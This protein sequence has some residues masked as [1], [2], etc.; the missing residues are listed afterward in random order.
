M[1]AW[2]PGSYMIR[3]L[4]ANIVSVRAEADG[5]PL[6]LTKTDKSTWLAA[7][8][9]SQVTLV[10][11]IFAFDDSVRGAYL[12]TLRG[13]FDGACVFPAVVGQ[14][15]CECVVDIVAPAFATGSNWRV[16]TSMQA[17]QAETNAFGSYH[18]S[19]YA[20][21]IDHPVAMGDF[22]FGEFDVRGIPHRI[23]LPADDQVD[24]PRLCADLQAL[25]ACHVDFLRPPADLDRYLF[26]VNS[27]ESGYG[28]LEHR[29]S[30]SLMCSRSD[31]PKV[32]QSGVSE[33]YRKF[34]GLCS[35]EYFHL[36]N[37]KRIRPAA[38]ANGK[39][40]KENYTGLLWVF[41]GITS[42]YDDLL[43][44]RSGLIT[45][46]SYLE[47][48][49]RTITRVERTRGRFRQSVEESSFDAWTKFYKRTVNTNNAVVSYYAKGSLIALALDL[50]IR[51]QSAGEFSLDDVMHAA[52]REYGV[53]GKGM[54]EG[55]L[56]S[57]A[58]SVTG[59][60]LQDFFAQFV[61]GT[62]DLPLQ[63][64]LIDVGLQLHRRPQLGPADNGGKPAAAGD[65]QPT[66]WFGA[67][68]QNSGSSTRVMSVHSDS[69][70]EVSGVAPGDE[71]VALGGA[72]L[73]IANINNRLQSFEP[74]DTA[75]LT[76]FRDHRLLN[77]TLAF[78]T[79][80]PDD[81]AYFTVSDTA[82]DD[83][84]KRRARWLTAT[85]G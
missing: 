8:A 66:V 34:L 3:D 71:L 77:L 67:V 74:G 52:W 70:A 26:I 80:A 61:R 54:P 65:V 4:A 21:L 78:A 14:E 31:L 30:T 5:E 16:A 7:P 46:E 83:A 32:G 72:R 84:H 81:T 11:E 29:W 42:Y 2:I 55:G 39:L 6:E 33:N 69:P 13:F 63:E 44:K 9:A 64:L 48:V 51:K 22:A 40:T 41:E 49:A 57:L 36:W 85:D 50:T 19:D 53:T 58:G 27:K 60:P 43:L 62:S 28:G 17:L 82:E 37:V 18:C 25:C 12:D 45:E 68:L 20:E 38:H 56:E 15:S 35:H 59:L 23:A 75:T 73:T 76:V 24:L 47:L 1:P 10:A 79:Q